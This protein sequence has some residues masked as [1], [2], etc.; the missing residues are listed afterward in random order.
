MKT[1]IDI[2]ILEDYLD[3]KLSSEKQKEVETALI[4]DSDLRKELE[5]L[6]L[7]RESIQLAGWKKLIEETQSNYLSTRTTQKIYPDKYLGKNPWYLRIAASISILL[8]GLASFLYVNTS[9]EALQ[10]EFISY[11]VPVMRGNSNLENKMKEYYQNKEFQKAI[12]LAEE[13]AFIDRESKFILAMSYLELNQGNEASPILLELQEENIED[14]Q[15]WFQE[16]IDYYLIKAYIVQGDFSKA[17]IQ[18]EKIKSNPRHKYRR[19]FDRWDIVR[20]Q[21]LELKY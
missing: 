6:K 2:S 16:E 10:K 14:G 21:L 15:S 7:N 5:I 20:I 12:Q 3:Q 19:S 9:P 4:Q 1:N 18:L 11:Q 8:I 13:E 17:K